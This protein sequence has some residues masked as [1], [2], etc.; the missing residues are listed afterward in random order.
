MAKYNKKIV[1]VICDL[2]S[3]DSYTVLEICSLSGISE[4]T[5]YCWKRDKPEFSEA[6]TRARDRFDELIVKEAKNSLR[7]KINGYEVEE[8]KT[9]YTESKEVDPTTGKP[10]PK[11]KEKTTVKK[12]FQPDTAAIVFA[13]TNKASEEWK[14][15]H[16]N[17]V[18][19]KDGKDLIP[20][21]V[22]TKQEA[23]DLLNKIENDC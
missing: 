19:G 10:R 18:T 7:K 8:T 11:I 12:H 15:K 9:V 13:L 22:L 3:N 20:A 5:Y 1:K 14:N 16:N 4:E 2:L 21:R 6:V 23:K 17:E